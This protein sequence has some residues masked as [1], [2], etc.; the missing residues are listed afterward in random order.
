MSIFFKLGGTPESGAHSVVFMYASADTFCAVH[1]S[2]P[3]ASGS[4]SSQ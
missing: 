2:D 4:C 3:C 1:T